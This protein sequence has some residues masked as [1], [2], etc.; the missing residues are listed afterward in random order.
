MLISYTHDRVLIAWPIST[1]RNQV[2]LSTPCPTSQTVCAPVKEIGIVPS[3]L[4]SLLSKEPFLFVMLCRQKI[5]FMEIFHQKIVQRLTV[6]RS[7]CSISPPIIEFRPHVDSPYSHDSARCA[8]F[9][10]YD[11]PHEQQSDRGKGKYLCTNDARIDVL[12]A[13]APKV[14]FRG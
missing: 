5:T 10:S 1:W 3:R 2:M 4:H 12:V 6:Y 7:C 13:S 14:E 9:I 8:Y 11:R